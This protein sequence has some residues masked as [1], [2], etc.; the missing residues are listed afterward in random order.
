M[1]DIRFITAEYAE[2]IENNKNS[3]IELFR[4]MGHPE[5]AEKLIRELDEIS[6]ENRIK[7]A[8]AGQ[9][10]AG[11]STIISALTG[12]NTLKI[13]SNISTEYAKDYSWGNVVLTD[14]PG[15]YTGNAEHD[16]RTIEA[17]SR[18]DL[19]IY[20]ITSDLFNQ[21]TLKDFKR[22]AY[23]ENY[24]RKMFLVINKMSKESGN[25]E[26]LKENYSLSLNIS[27]SPN[28][29]DEFRYAFF[30]AK[31]YRDGLKDHDADLMKYSHFEDFIV[32]LN[33]FIR[34]KGEIGKFDTP[35]MI[36]KSYIDDY[37]EG[38][39]QDD[40]NKEYSALLSRLERAVYEI[41][42]RISDEAEHLIR[43]GLKPIIDKGFELSGKIGL[44]E[45][46][47]SEKDLEELVKKCCDSLNNKL[48]ELCEKGYSQLQ[49]KI[50]GIL[51]SDLAVVFFDSVK[52]INSRASIFEN[53]DNKVKRMQ[54]ESIN[55]IVE[56]VTG[57]T[58]ELATKSGVQSAGF[59][60]RAS[61][62]SGSQIHQVVLNI[63]RTLGHKFRPW[64]A[65]NIAK[66]IGN[67][68]KAIGPIMGVLSIAL[69]VKDMIKEAEQDKK[70][71]VARIE[72]RKSYEDIESDLEQQY[73][74]ELRNMFTSFDNVTRQVQEDREKVQN[75]MKKNN[76]TVKRLLDIRRDLIDIQSNLFC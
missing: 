76:D 44:E 62:A 74:D 3:L 15:L 20:C 67:V 41:R 31:D 57:K 6:A 54:F 17:I 30:D 56:R 68:A 24:K 60:L 9:Y 14:T 52:N 66:H 75:V 28:S 23:K 72:C 22:W 58:V 53:K 64:E 38:L 37:I 71:E 27:L 55:E 48:S 35:V 46:V 4:T 43:S 51:Q 26:D 16:T 59:F 36:L 5:I 32:I 45:I 8:F 34:D 47:F 69:E 18:S 42:R 49:E 1:N 12:D 29:L 7:L 50:E 70:L 63:G 33:D 13:D 2:R 10:S 73:R 19:L 40:S 21:Y 65:V 61:E 39:S 25:Y 11:K